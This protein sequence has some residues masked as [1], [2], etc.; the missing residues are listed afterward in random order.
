M[1]TLNIS[2]AEYRDIPAVNASILKQGLKSMRHMRHAI[3]CKQPDTPSMRIGRAVHTLAL[4]PHLFTEEYVVYDGVRR[5]KTWEAYKESKPDVDILN[6]SEFNQVQAMAERVA[7]HSDASALIKGADVELTVKAQEEAYNVLCKGRVDI[8]NNGT[9]AD[10]KTTSGI[11]PREFARAFE[12][13]AYHVSLGLYARWLRKNGYTVDGVEII[14]VENKP[15]YD[16][17]VYRIPM[18]VIEHGEVVGVDLVR[19]YREAMDSGDWPGVAPEAEDL[20]F[21]GWQFPGA[22]RPDAEPV[23]IV[24]TLK[25]VF[26]D[27]KEVTE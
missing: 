2:F 20:E 26:P 13:F 17:A 8:W 9:L 10:I 16:V 11:T 21:A 3:D 12:N 5:G 18:W 1:E 7:S 27:L 22:A 6:P 19:R 4:E 25:S 14:T 23:D 24:S 15:P